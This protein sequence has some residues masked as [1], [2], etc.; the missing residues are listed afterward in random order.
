MNKTFRFLRALR[1]LTPR[2]TWGNFV[3]T[4][5]VAG[6]NNAFS[7]SW[8]QGGEDL[9]LLHA[10]AGKKD[11]LFIDVGAHHPFRFSVTQ[12][13]SRLGWRGVNVDA[14]GELIDVFN[15]ERSRDINICA[16]VGTE[17]SYT[18]TIFKEPAL[19]SVNGEWKDKFLA[20]GWE[21]EKTVTVPGITL[22]DIYDQNFSNDCIDLLSIDAEG[23]DFN[24]LK[25]MEFE[26]LEKARFPRFLLLEAAPPVKSALKTDSVEYAMGLGYEP[27]YVLPMSTLLQR[28]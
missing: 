20:D 9:A 1:L 17:K 2:K 6:F 24:V 15:R 5:E 12:H 21:I 19:S 28:G 25:S 7:I 10:I 8:S 26:S 16:A 23:S 4:S 3:Q 14:N 18:F 13:L 27:L 22:R 11:G